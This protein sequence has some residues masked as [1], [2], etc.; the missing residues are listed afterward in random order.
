MPN[1]AMQLPRLIAA[2]AVG[3]AAGLGCTP[4][5]T[6]DGDT[7]EQSV[8]GYASDTAITAKVKAAFVAEPS[9]KAMNIAVETNQ[10]VV[11]LSGTVDTTAQSETATR[12]ASGVAG[13]KQVNNDLKVKSP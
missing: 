3:A 8:G 2:G 4:H 6:G 7:G 10:G 9:L 1:R 13:V 5:A 11:Q 12:V